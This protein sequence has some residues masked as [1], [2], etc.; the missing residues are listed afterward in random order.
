MSHAS[1]VIISLEAWL[2]FINMSSYS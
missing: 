2:I 1:T